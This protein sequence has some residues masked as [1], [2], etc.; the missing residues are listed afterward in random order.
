MRTGRSGSMIERRGKQTVRVLLC[1]LFTAVMLGL[2][3]C[4]WVPWGPWWGPERGGGERGG[5]DRG[6]H[7]GER[8]EGHER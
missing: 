8:G 1:L 7:H 5:G 4:I 2:S 3:G 6:E